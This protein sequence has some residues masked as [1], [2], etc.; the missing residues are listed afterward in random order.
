MTFIEQ[1]HQSI[2]NRLQELRSEISKIEDA[3]R[4][5]NNGAAKPQ[6]KAHSNG[7]RRPSQPAARKPRPASK[8][9]RAEQLEQLLGESSDGLSTSVIAQR[10]GAVP[11]Q[12]L[13]LLR[14]LEQAGRVRRTGE[15]RGTRWHL[16]T[17]EDRIA[18]RAAELA[19][20]SKVPV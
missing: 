5:L 7:N 13:A 3:Y 14:E 9:M 1:L 8:V 10:G 16:V 20:R 11:A 6:A 2:A 17:D 12:V 15:R 18:Q 19:G 4:A